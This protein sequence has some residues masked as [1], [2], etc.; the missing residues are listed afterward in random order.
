MLQW[1]RKM[2]FQNLAFRFSAL[3]EELLLSSPSETCFISLVLPPSIL[4]ISYNENS[5]LIS[6]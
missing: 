4:C 6:L 5:I 3:R 1:F 2:E